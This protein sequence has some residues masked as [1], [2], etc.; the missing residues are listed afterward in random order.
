MV[1]LVISVSLSPPI[2]TESSQSSDE[3]ALASYRAAERRAIHKTERGA[4]SIPSRLAVCSF[5]AKD[6]ALP[7]TASSESDSQGLQTLEPRELSKQ[8]VPR[9]SAKKLAQIQVHILVLYWHSGLHLE[10]GTR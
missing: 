10:I 3:G 1:G 9:L 8:K 5:S 4:P 7:T 2:G 6:Q